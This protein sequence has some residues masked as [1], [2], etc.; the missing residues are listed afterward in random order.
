MAL[1]SLAQTAMTGT[2]TG[3]LDLG[4]AKLTLVLNVSTDADGTTQC[5]LDSPD[6]GARGIKASVS[7]CSDDS[8]SVAVPAIGASYSAR[9]AGEMLK[10]TFTQMGHSL[11]LDLT[12][13]EESIN[14]PQT[15][16]GPVPYKTEEVTFTNADEGATLSGTLTYPTGYTNSAD[17]PVVL[18]VT[19]SGLQ[20]RDEEIM[21]HKPFLVIADYLARNGIA[22]LR[23]D[24]RGTGKSQGGDNTQATTL[25]Y[26]A[27]AQAGITYLKCAK[28]FGKIGILGHSEGANIAFIIGAREKAD[29]VVS[30]AAVGVKGDT[31]LTA[32]ANCVM[33]LNG[34][35]GTASTTEYRNLVL[36][37]NQPWLSWFINYDPTGE[38]SA[39]RCPVFAA[40]GD[41]DC[42]VISSLNL[43]AIKAA[44]PAGETNRI[45]EYPGLNHLFQECTT[46]NP[47]EYHNIEQTIS[48]RVLK[49]I[50]NWINNLK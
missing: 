28:K 5:T 31:A 32:Q 11:P 34:M 9:R 6:Q 38:I 3:K 8:I 41:K 45:I 20:N 48:P 43:A 46:G 49:D 44:L 15:P 27:D 4:M 36:M 13:G 23:Y 30:L 25:N 39:T 47:T 17:V 14:R 16:V 2:W 12:K 42:Q 24:D 35:P 19:G 50:T 22:S 21:D 1:T 40:N 29:F 18:M 37:Q 26:A 10:G 33:R 7:H